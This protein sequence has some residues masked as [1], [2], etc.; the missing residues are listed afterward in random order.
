MPANSWLGRKD[1]AALFARR[2]QGQKQAPQF[3]TFALRQPRRENALDLLDTWTQRREIFLAFGSQEQHIT[4]L[5]DGIVRAFDQ[6]VANHARDEIGDGRTVHVEFIAQLPLIY[7]GR[8]LQDF[9]RRVLDARDLG[10]DLAEP[11]RYVA[12]LGAAYQASREFRKRFGVVVFSWQFPGVQEE[13]VIVR[14]M[15]RKNAPNSA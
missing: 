8:F 15:G 3:Q 6:I 11:H 13:G 10:G 2:Q 5:V 1:E 7:A 9:E 12:L 4:P 14:K